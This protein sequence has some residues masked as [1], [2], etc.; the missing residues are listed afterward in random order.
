M[1]Y[2]PRNSAFLAGIIIVVASSYTLLTG[3]VRGDVFVGNDR[4]FIGIP[5]LLFGLYCI[6]I[7]Y[8]KK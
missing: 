2:I 7:S 6:Y 3:N 8:Y 5:F 1:K 4:Y